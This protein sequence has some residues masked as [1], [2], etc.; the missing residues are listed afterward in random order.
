[1]KIEFD[2]SK[3]GYCLRID[4]INHNI[5]I[6]KLYYSIKTKKYYYLCDNQIKKD[7]SLYFYT[8][9]QHNLVLANDKCFCKFCKI[10][11]TEIKCINCGSK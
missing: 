9:S 1:M 3:K 4:N 5:L 11:N 7:Y 6:P 10:K 8:W 2:C